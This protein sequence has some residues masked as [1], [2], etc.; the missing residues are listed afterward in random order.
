MA[1][2]N[3]RNKNTDLNKVW[4]NGKTANVVGLLVRKLRRERGLTQEQ[5]AAQ[6]QVRGLNLSRSTLAKIEARVRFIKAC[7]LFIIAKVLNVAMEDFYPADFGGR[8]TR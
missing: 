5:L 2:K 1:N 4:A 7:E 8:R 6:C 3:R